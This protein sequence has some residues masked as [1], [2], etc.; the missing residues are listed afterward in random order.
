MAGYRRYRVELHERSGEVI[1]FRAGRP[2]KS[3]VFRGR[4]ASEFWREFALPYNQG[5]P[6]PTASAELVGRDR[7]RIIVAA[8]RIDVT[9]RFQRPVP[10]DLVA[11]LGRVQEK[12]RKPRGSTSVRNPANRSKEAA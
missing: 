5:K 12:P 2:A 7:L 4:L 10:E 3:R 1:W 6:V 8:G 9:L 11:E